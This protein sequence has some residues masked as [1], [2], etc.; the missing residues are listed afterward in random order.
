MSRAF[1]LS[2]L[3]LSLFFY[4]LSLSLSLFILFVV[5]FLFTRYLVESVRSNKPVYAGRLK[6][7]GRSSLLDIA[8]GV[9]PSRSIVGYKKR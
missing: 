2:A 1:Q 7:A 8:T 3:F 4:F 9:T 5:G 6:M